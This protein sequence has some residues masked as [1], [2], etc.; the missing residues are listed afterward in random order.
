[1]GIVLSVVLAKVRNKGPILQRLGSDLGR[2]TQNYGPGG[3]IRSPCQTGLEHGTCLDQRLALIV[4]SDR[5]KG[6]IGGGGSQGGSPSI[7]KP[8]LF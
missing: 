2:F 5:I 7:T 6:G 3:D 8:I 4:E 1:M